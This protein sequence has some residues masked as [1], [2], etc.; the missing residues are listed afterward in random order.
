MK[1][2][3]QEA[4]PFEQ[5][6]YDLNGI[7]KHIELCA[8]TCYKSEDK[9]TET[10]AKDFVDRMISS[11][12]LAMLEHGTVYLI[13][14]NTDMFNFY[15]KNKY[16]KVLGTHRDDIRYF[17]ITTNY[18]VIIE[19]KRESD[20][21]YIYSP[22]YH[23]YKRYTFKFITNRQVSH[24]FVRHRVF[25]FAQESTRF[26]NYTKDKFG[27]ELTFINYNIP[28]TESLQNIEDTYFR[29]INVGFTAEY[30]A[31]ILPNCTKTELIM[32]GFRNDWEHFVKLRSEGKT[33]KPHPQAKE[34]ADVV[35]RILDL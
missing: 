27:N 10:S 6:E 12:H 4:I 11:G 30:A 32:T 16:S 18:R 17:Y 2:I 24:E 29:L 22:T 13:T 34:L 23:H 19:N 15:N 25:S 8:R 1:L 33:G 7:Y 20:L 14:T 31:Q 21:E 9:I 28:N 35:K 3:N 26:C 5:L